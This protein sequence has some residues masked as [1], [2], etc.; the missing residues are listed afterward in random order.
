MSPLT[1]PNV[2]AASRIMLPAYPVLMAVIGLNYLATPSARL[3]RTPSLAYA[4]SLLPLEGWGALFLG[5]AGLMV[6]ALLLHRREWYLYALSLTV[7][8]QAVWAVVFL[9]AIPAGASPSAWVWPAFV[10]VACA[11]S[12]RSLARGEV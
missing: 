9:A 3:A 12:W 5:I 1:R 10:A 8:T 4:D 7:V 6:A 2:T 11:A